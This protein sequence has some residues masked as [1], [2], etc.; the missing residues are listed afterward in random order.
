MPGQGLHKHWGQLPVGEHVGTGQE[1]LGQE[2]V[3][4]GD[5]KPAGIAIV[6][7]GAVGVGGGPTSA[8]SVVSPSQLRP[9]AGENCPE[10]TGKAQMMSSF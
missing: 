6:E 10:S 1:Q 8:E 2:G 9:W 3:D 7:K 5:N 4:N